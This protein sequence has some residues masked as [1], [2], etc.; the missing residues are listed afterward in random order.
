MLL[1]GM[2]PSPHRMLAAFVAAFAGLLGVRSLSAAF[3]A[4]PKNPWTPKNSASQRYLRKQSGATDGV[5]VV[6]GSTAGRDS[7]CGAAALVLAAGGLV[8]RNLERRRAAAKVQ[9]NAFSSGSSGFM[10]ASCASSSLGMSYATPAPIEAEPA[11]SGVAGMGMKGQVWWIRNN[12]IND[13]PTKGGSHIFDWRR[14]ESRRRGE[15][16]FRHDV[17]NFELCVH[18]IIP[19]PGSFKR[20]VVRGRGKYGSH[21][22]SCGYGIENGG[23]KRRG[24]RTLN[25][26]YEGGNKPIARITPK[27]TKEQMEEKKKDPYTHIPLHVL[28]MCEDND[29]V[30]FNDLFLRG[31]PVKKIRT[32][33]SIRLDA[34]KVT[35]KDSDEFNVKNL[36]VY[37]HIFEPPAREKIESL[38]G[39]CIRLSDSHRIP[40]TAEY[41]TTKIDPIEESGSE[42][43]DETSDAEA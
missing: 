22:R 33:R 18:N 15:E 23:A 34:T 32:F 7:L 28:N 41:L 43:K 25:P 35:G 11:C 30:D 2:A 42:E 21:G 40:I 6:A 36:T 4:V 20:K 16:L 19:A 24:R 31:L 29:E 26:G 12:G 14:R 38:G 8:C 13:G 9:R 17:D 1:L 5:D 37:A 39:K 27:L 3:A 10:G